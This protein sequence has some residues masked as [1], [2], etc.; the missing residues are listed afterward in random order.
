MA[1]PLIAQ[2]I[3]SQPDFPKPI[4]RAARATYK[5][6][7]TARMG[8]GMFA[9]C[10]LKPGDLVL[11]ERPVLVYPN[12][13]LGDHNAA[14]ETALEYMTAED[15]IAYRKLASSAPIVAPG[16]GD[17]VRIATTNCFQM[18]PDIPG[19]SNDRYSIGDYRAMYLVTSRIN[20]SCSPN[21]IA[22]FHY[23]TFS[24]VIRATREIWKG[25][26]ITTM[27]AGIDGPK[28]ERQA[29]LAFCMD[30]CGCTVCNDPA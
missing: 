26:E 5:I 21:T 7:R 17:L 25:E 18:P 13:F 12:H 24:F 2:L 1:E 30:A 28:A 8:S 22:D 23:P 10:K 15:R 4:L 9:K 29:R 11:A 16:A 19:G 20:H 14:F 27:Y 3:S 6:R